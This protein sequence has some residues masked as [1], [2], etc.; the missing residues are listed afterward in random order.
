MTDTAEVH[1]QLEER[2]ELEP[3]P[4]STARARELVRGVLGGSA[5]DADA[6][7][8]VA[9]ELVTNAVVHAGTALEVAVRRG[10]PARVAVRDRM[11]LS[12]RVA[13]LVAEPAPQPS[14]GAT[15]GRGLPLA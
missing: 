11:P 2:L 7:V 13:R 12:A 1:E 5:V 9:S 3:V 4:I 10:P 14:A 6:A 8:L 15:G